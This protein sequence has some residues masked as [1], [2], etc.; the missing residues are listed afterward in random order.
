[1][2]PPAGHA[3][4][5]CPQLSIV[6]FVALIV[7]PVCVPG[8]IPNPYVPLPK[9]MFSVCEPEPALPATTA[10]PPLAADTVMIDDVPPR[11]KNVLL[12]AMV[13]EPPAL[14]ATIAVPPTDAA[15]VIV[16]ELPPD[17]M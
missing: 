16:D 2:P 11:V 8:V 9:P 5:S 13:P 7:V 4:T 6:Q 14:P 12:Y 17:R 15:T 1:M 3:T 10:A